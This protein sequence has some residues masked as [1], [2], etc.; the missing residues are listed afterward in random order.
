MILIVSL[1]EQSNVS[2]NLEKTDTTFECRHC[3]NRGYMDILATTE[4]Q[5]SVIEDNRE[6]IFSPN[7]D[8][9]KIGRC[10]N[11]MEVNIIFSRVNDDGFNELNVEENIILPKL[12][13]ENLKGLFGKPL[14]ASQFECDVFMVMPFAD[15]FTS[16]YENHI[17]PIVKAQNLEI[18]RGDDFYT[19]QSIM[20]DIWS[21]IVACKFVIAEC[22]DK[23]ANVFYELGIAHTIGRPAIL[24]TQS[25]D[26]IPFDLRHIR[27]IEYED[28]IKGKKKLESDL[29]DAII[30]IRQ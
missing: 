15:K 10:P 24:I 17:K 27:A 26:D 25:I 13:G 9:W 5:D 3:Q 7:Y 12:P 6:E 29:S 22:T 18:I 2:T 4:H 19:K 14:G 16:I 30:K 11:C 28:S 21:A 8:T 1:E 23:N 20:R